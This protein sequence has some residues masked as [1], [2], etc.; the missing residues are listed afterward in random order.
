MT[1]F[2]VL[3]LRDLLPKPDGYALLS[4]HYRGQ[5]GSTIAEI[6]KGILKS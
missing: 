3:L 6:E 4:L 5:L 1:H 2:I